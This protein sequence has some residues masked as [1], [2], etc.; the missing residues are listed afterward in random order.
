MLSIFFFTGLYSLFKCLNILGGCKQRSKLGDVK[1]LPLWN[2]W[3]LYHRDFG[4]LS[5]LFLEFVEYLLMIFALLV[6]SFDPLVHHVE[7][8]TK[9]FHVHFQVGH[10]VFGITTFLLKFFAN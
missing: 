8:H 9:R 6:E 4:S 2:Q 10:F 3:H 7:V 5:G 1:V